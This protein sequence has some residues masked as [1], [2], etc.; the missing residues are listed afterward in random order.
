M[1]ALR[2][3]RPSPR[4]DLTLAATLLQ[5]QWGREA[6]QFLGHRRGLPPAPPESATQP[7]LY[8]VKAD[9]VDQ[10]HRPAESALGYNRQLWLDK[11]ECC[12]YS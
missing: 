2:L 9:R 12:G 8:S 4:R 7:L 11:M 5:D 3:L 10:K 6:L 1:R